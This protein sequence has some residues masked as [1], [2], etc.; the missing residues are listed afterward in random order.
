LQPCRSRCRPCTWSNG[1]TAPLPMTPLSDSFG[2]QAP[3]RA[4][5][6]AGRCSQRRGH[7]V[8]GRWSRVAELGGSGIV[9]SCVCIVPWSPSTCCTPAAFKGIPPHDDVVVVIT[10]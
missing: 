4:R 3:D 7:V 1:S 6:E 2:R 5:Q 9:C 8:T 10:Y